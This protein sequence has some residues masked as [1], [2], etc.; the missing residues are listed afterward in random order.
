MQKNNK[1][2]V[3]TYLLHLREDGV[4]W[5]ELTY[6]T[7]MGKGKSRC[8]SEIRFESAESTVLSLQYKPRWSGGR[9][10]FKDV[11]RKR[12]RVHGKTKTR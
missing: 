11:A 3:P 6:G 12:S 7:F 8:F 4:G 5:W 2:K 9:L 10:L 1:G